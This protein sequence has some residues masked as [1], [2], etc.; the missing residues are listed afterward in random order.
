MDK[1]AKMATPFPPQDLHPSHKCKLQRLRALY[2][3]PKKV[4]GSTIQIPQESA[5]ERY[6]N[7]PRKCL[8]AIYK[9]T[10]K[11]LG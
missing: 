2:K 4:L 10:K 8:G 3:Y 6:T 9:Y 7:T 11:V 5:W 1:M